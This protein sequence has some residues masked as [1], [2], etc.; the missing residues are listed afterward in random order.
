VPI[1]PNNKYVFSPFPSVFATADAIIA[2]NF[3][4]VRER[5]SGR[6]PRDGGR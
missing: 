5:I 1:G 6:S 3:S 2:R 4:R